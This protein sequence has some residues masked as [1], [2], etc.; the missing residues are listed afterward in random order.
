MEVAA[1]ACQLMKGL[2]TDLTCSGMSQTVN[3]SGLMAS[4]VYFLFGFF[5][6]A[7]KM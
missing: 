2:G 4:V 6:E 3:I 5:N 1:E 7:L